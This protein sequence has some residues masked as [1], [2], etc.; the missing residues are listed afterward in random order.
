EHRAHRAIEDVDAV[1]TQ[2]VMERSHGAFQYSGRV[3]SASTRPGTRKRLA[4]SIA[5]RSR[6]GVEA[7]G[8]STGL[9]DLEDLRPTGRAGA[10]SGWP[11]VLHGDRLGVFDLLLRPALNTVAFQS[12]PS[13][14]FEHCAGSDPKSDP[15]DS[16]PRSPPSGGCRAPSCLR[17]HK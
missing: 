8:T 14:L 5:R 1:V 4:I 7:R 12:S 16:Y 6:V 2:G 11:A 9:A 17:S 15:L 10:L 3:T 13:S